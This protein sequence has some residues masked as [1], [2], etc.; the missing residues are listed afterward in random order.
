MTRQTRGLA[1]FYRR[2]LG[3]AYREGDEP[4]AKGGA[5]PRR[6]DWL[7]LLEPQGTARLAFQQVEELRP[8]TWPAPDVPQQLHLDLCVP[9]AEAL[10]AQHERVLSLGATLLED[11]SD[12]PDE[13][14]YVYADPA[15]HPFC[16]FVAPEGS[17]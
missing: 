8:S 5:D 6:Q 10:E 7:V 4:P 2:L 1:D 12:D 15:G 3:Y 17:P 9:D 11:R 13:P 14:L 16:V